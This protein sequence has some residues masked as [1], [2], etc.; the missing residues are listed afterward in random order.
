[1]VAHLNGVQGA[2]GSNPL[3]PTIFLA[4]GIIPAE[5]LVKASWQVY[6]SESVNDV[7][8]RH[9]QG[10]SGSNPLSPTIFSD[11]EKMVECL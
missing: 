8:C 2:S 7:V 3:S 10:A 11:K 6:L 4:H 5:A 1:M 9:E